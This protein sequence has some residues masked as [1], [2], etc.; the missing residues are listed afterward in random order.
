M[1]RQQKISEMSYAVQVFFMFLLILASQAFLQTRLTMKFYSMIIT[2]LLLIA[3]QTQAKDLHLPAIQV[4][5]IQDKASNRNYELYIKLP[6]GYDAKADKKYPVL[7]IVD[8]LWNIEVISGS[9]EHFVK[10]A[11]LVGISWEKGMTPQQ[12][13]MRDYMPTEYKGSNYQHATG[14]ADKH[15]AFLNN[16]VF[17]HIESKYQADPKR[18]SYYGFSVGGTFGSYILLTQPKTFKNYIIGSPATLFGGDF[19]HQHKSI[20]PAIPQS[21]D[22]NVFLSVGQG[23]EAEY[24]DHAFSLMRFLKSRQ[25]P[26]NA[27]EFKVVEAPDHGQ[28]FPLSAIQSLAWFSKI[29]KQTHL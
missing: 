28:A 22:A 6:E 23:E 19:I 7:Y 17:T 2:G 1:E 8:A 29:D 26:D 14:Q 25:T 20:S 9:I 4:T 12:S 27:L 15:L 11:I 13:R 5:P 3:A 16:D 10:D 24:V 18:R 21:L